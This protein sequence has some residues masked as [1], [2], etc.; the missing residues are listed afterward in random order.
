MKIINMED[1]ENF[2]QLEKIGIMLAGSPGSK[3]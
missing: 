3:F 2:E 1:L